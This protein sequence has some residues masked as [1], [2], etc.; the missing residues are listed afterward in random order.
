MKHA[1]YDYLRVK[2]SAQVFKLLSKTQDFSVLTRNMK[3]QEKYRE[4]FS[5]YPRLSP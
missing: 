4:N 1:N 5:A 2:L 3:R